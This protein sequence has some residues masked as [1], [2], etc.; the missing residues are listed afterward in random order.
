[1]KLE[2]VN[3]NLYL[4]VNTFLFEGLVKFEQQ[5]YFTSDY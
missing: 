2:Q 3:I 5:K 4:P 1:M